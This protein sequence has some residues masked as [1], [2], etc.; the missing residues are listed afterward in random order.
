MVR[1][2]QRA[3]LQPRGALLLLL[4]YAAEMMPKDRVGYSD[5]LALHIHSVLN[6]L[7]AE[8]AAA[9]AVCFLFMSCLRICSLSF[10]CDAELQIDNIYIGGSKGNERQY[11]VRTQMKKMT[12]LVLVCCC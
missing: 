5:T 9:G 8:A 3:L 2:G 10:V 11:V 12:L 4:P 7:R 1:F 6:L